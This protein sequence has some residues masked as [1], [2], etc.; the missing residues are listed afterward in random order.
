MLCVCEF[1]FDSSIDINCL[2]LRGGHLN[3]TSPA[4]CH[5]RRVPELPQA[6]RALHGGQRCQKCRTRPHLTLIKSIRAPKSVKT[7]TF[8][9][10]IARLFSRTPA[11]STSAPVYSS[12]YRV[13]VPVPV[14]APHSCSHS[15]NCLTRLN[16]AS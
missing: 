9:R 13:P 2:L 16:V 15:L 5:T 3:D 8:S 7:T 6:G 11:P 1:H 4:A 10:V 14:P 12:A